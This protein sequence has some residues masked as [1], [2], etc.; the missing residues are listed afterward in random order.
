[1]LHDTYAT[2]IVRCESLAFLLMK[3][4]ILALFIALGCDTAL[5]QTTV[6]ANL[7]Q[8][9]PSF[10][11]STPR[12]TFYFSIAPAY[13]GFSS[14]LLTWGTGSTKDGIVVKNNL[15]YYTVTDIN[16]TNNVVT[17]DSV[18]DIYSF[19]YAPPSS[20]FYG[21]LSFVRSWDTGDSKQDVPL[22][23]SEP[24]SFQWDVVVSNTHY[25]GSCSCT[26]TQV[27]SLLEKQGPDGPIGFQGMGNQSRFSNWTALT[28]L[29]KKSQ[30]DGRAILF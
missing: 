24:N 2:C 22:K 14:L 6:P 30:F 7:L 23:R 4:F 9:S 17:P 21:R 5:A 25:V 11:G 26:F 8:G 12:P 3:F 16:Q 29:P 18:N 13:R 28:V 1:M 19:Q 10:V 27:Q 20:S 15:W